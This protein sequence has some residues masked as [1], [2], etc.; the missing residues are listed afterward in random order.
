MVGEKTYQQKAEGQRQDPAEILM[1]YFFHEQMSTG[2]FRYGE[3]YVREP[4][5]S[6][7]ILSRKELLV[8]SVGTDIIQKVN[9]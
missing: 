9:A 3:P 1:E 6:S 5:M 4:H 7:N 2:L 8:K